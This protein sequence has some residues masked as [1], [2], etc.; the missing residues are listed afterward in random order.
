MKKEH[1]REYILTLNDRRLKN[2]IMKTKDINLG[3]LF[4]WQV[5]VEALNAKYPKWTELREVVAVRRNTPKR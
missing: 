5:S 2:G 4:E 3:K 1:K